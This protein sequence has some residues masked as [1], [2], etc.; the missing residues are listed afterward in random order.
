MSLQFIRFVRSVFEPTTKLHNTATEATS[1]NLFHPRRFTNSDFQRTLVI[2]KLKPELKLP[3][4]RVVI[5]ETFEVSPT[6]RKFLAKNLILAILAFGYISCHY[7]LSLAAA[8]R[9]CHK[10]LLC[11]NFFVSKMLRGGV[12]GQRFFCAG[13]KKFA[14]DREL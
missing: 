10:Q 8:K 3:L 13:K 2:L 6:F 7:Q 1:A 12:L 5:F 11:H 4:I 9:S 14:A